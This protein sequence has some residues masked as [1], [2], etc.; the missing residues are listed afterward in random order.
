MRR[1]S[2]STG[3]DCPVGLL[4]EVGALEGLP[5][6]DAE[7]IQKKIEWLWA[8]RSYVRHYPLSANLSGYYKRRVGSFRI[9]YT[10]DDKPDDMIIHRVGLRDEIYQSFS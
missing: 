3:D 6:K 4:Y 1:G 5:Q 9:V 10:Y 2:D 7:R 8:N